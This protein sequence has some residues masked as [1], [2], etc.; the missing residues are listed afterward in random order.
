MK[1]IILFFLMLTTLTL[2]GC[3]T[4]D[5]FVGVWTYNDLPRILQQVKD[6]PFFTSADTITIHINKTDGE[7]ELQILQGGMASM[8]EG[9]IKG[10]RV[11]RDDIE[12][13]RSGQW[14]SS[15]LISP[16]S[17]KITTNGDSLIVKFDGRPEQF[18]VLEFKTDGKNMRMVRND[19]F[20]PYGMPDN[21][22]QMPLNHYSESEFQKIK[23][24]F[25]KVRADALEKLIEKGAPSNELQK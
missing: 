25:Q 7:Y 18:S 9:Y 24:E 6:D 14:W 1:K 23:L 12:S 16:S 21:F 20:K 2:S 15:T 8:N 5:K 11:N 13:L 19:Y 22:L 4:D 10:N 17:Y 3:G